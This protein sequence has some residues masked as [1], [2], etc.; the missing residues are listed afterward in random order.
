MDIIAA[1]A[2]IFQFCKANS[3]QNIKYE[4]QIFIAIK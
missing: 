4:K 3:Q 2:E 1:F